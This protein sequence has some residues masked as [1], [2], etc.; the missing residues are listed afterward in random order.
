MAGRSGR[1][2]IAVGVVGALLA[3]YGIGISTREDTGSA[4]APKPSIITTAYV[5]PQ[6]R[7]VV[8]LSTTPLENLPVLAEPPI[9]DVTP[10]SLTSV[11]DPA[12]LASQEPT[13]PPPSLQRNDLVPPS[14]ALPPPDMPGLSAAPMVV[15]GPIL[16]PQ[17]APDLKP[18][19][20]P[21]ADPI[22]AADDF[23]ARSLKEAETAVEALNKEK[24]ELKERLAKVEQGLN[25][26]KAAVNALKSH[27]RMLDSV[28]PNSART[29]FLA[30]DVEPELQP[31]DATDPDSL[32]SPPR[33]K[34]GTERRRD[35]FRPQTTRPS[36]PPP[37]EAETP[38]LTTPEPEAPKPAAPEQI[39]PPPV[40]PK[41]SAPA[42]PPP[43]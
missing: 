35:P 7:E 34:A 14:A 32:P 41:P 4:R 11:I 21:L 33:S 38:V 5:P 39:P 18:P 26:Y 8:P 37:D 1:L 29:R 10:T 12:G 16:Q 31:L 3:G 30:E 43:G 13:T 27:G 15:P 19:A 25:R 36:G 24:A 40:E 28:G 17:E 2:P 20:S 6:D 42:I 22:Q 23:V 9:A